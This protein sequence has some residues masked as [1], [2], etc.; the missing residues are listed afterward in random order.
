[1]AYPRP[2]RLSLSRAI[3]RTAAV[4]LAAGLFL[5]VG[6]GCVERELVVDSDPGGA[7]VYMNDEEVGRT[8][9]RRPFQWYGTYDVVVRKD[10]Y[11]TLR[12]TTPVIAP[13]WLWV[14]LDLI[15]EI[16]PV[17]IKDTHHVRYQ[18]K[19]ESD[20]TTDPAQM[21]ERAQDLQGKL[22][23]GQNTT[24]PATRAAKKS[25]SKPASTRSATLPET[26]R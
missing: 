10:G 7:L 18:L 25:T 17:P 13:G 12:T 23:D 16:L 19:A 11:E 3:R 9:L 1:M 6:G 21:I 20:V 14:P 8:P 15:C 26:T 5:A 4:A 24:R 22:E 2:T